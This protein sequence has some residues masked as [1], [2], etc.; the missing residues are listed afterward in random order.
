[1][2]FSI[3]QDK[4]DKILIDWGSKSNLRVR[5]GTVVY[6]IRCEMLGK[7]VIINSD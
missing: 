1:M 7:N 2:K 5:N 4:E 6:S 3:S